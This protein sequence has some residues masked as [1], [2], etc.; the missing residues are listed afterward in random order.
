ML[1][2][3]REITLCFQRLPFVSGGSMQHEM[4]HENAAPAL[5]NAVAR[6]PIDRMQAEYSRESRRMDKARDTARVT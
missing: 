1:H 3:L 4:R 5:W 6:W 2:L